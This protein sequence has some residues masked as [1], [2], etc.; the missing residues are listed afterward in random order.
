MRIN[1]IEVS[2]IRKKPWWMYIFPWLW[3]NTGIALY[4]NFY[5]SS[6]MYRNLNSERPTPRSISVALHE[7]EHLKRARIFGVIH[8]YAAYV[9]NRRFRFEEEIACKKVEISYLRTH[10]ESLDLT[11]A[12]R[13]LSG[14]LY[15]WCTSEKEALQR[16]ESL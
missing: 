15:G 7:L 8:Y 9:F 10:G 12:A 3:G 13:M 11:R 6:E 4:P 14:W 16:L 2:N 5:V 1:G